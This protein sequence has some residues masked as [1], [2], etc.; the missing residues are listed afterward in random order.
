MQKSD[1]LV[2]HELPYDIEQPKYRS[3]KQKTPEDEGKIFVSV[4][5]TR[6]P[7]NS[8]YNKDK[9]FA[10]P[11]ILAMTADEASSLET[12][13]RKL[14][15]RLESWSGVGQSIW[16]SE[17]SPVHAAVPTIQPSQACARAIIPDDEEDDS[18][19]EE[20]KTS[21]TG[22]NT[23][24][25]AFWHMPNRSHVS[26]YVARRP[27][28][29][30]NYQ[31]FINEVGVDRVTLG[32]RAISIQSGKAHEAQGSTSLNRIPGSFGGDET[33]DL[34]GDDDIQTK[35]VT[36]LPHETEGG[37]VAPVPILRTGET[38]LVEWATQFATAAFADDA[39]KKRSD[40]TERFA[41]QERIIDPV[42]QEKRKLG[43]GKLEKRAVSIDD[44]LDEF[45]KEEK[46]TED[47]TW[48]CPSCKK[49]QEA[50]KK[51]DLWK[52]P[53]V[54][55]IHLKRF[56][57]E[58][59]FRDKIDTLVDF[60]VDGLDL[61]ERVEGAKVAKSLTEAGASEDL[62][63]GSESLIYDLFAVDN[64]FGGRE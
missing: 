22:S 63:G 2:L 33:E 43:N 38:I 31:P 52:M 55:V 1:L 56:S 6:G 47:N 12:I 34:Y 36:Q 40:M 45:I 48:Y 25:P 46:L 32:E 28:S 10:E 21:P 60:P 26:F 5:H 44:L 16:A 18:Q 59:A 64:H 24:A 42:I 29:G 27:T 8:S 51:F 54:L 35:A 23:K 61:S 39:D 7:N 14:C 15:E 57:N 62:I 49:H 13:E 58:R 53:D 30:Y 19:M 11:F 9:L 4:F 41:A 17:S 37:S 50:Q 20:V 3:P